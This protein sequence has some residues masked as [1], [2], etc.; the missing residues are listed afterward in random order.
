MNEFN[1]RCG[2]CWCQ[3]EGI[4]FLFPKNK[5]TVLQIGKESEIW[6]SGEHSGCYFELVQYTGS[7]LFSKPLESIACH[8]QLADGTT[9]CRWKVSKHYPTS[10]YSLRFHT[11][12]DLVVE[13]VAF[14]LSALVVEQE[15]PPKFLLN[16]LTS[17]IGEW[18]IGVAVPFKFIFASAAHSNSISANVSMSI[19]PIASSEASNACASFARTR[20][21]NRLRQNI[22]INSKMENF[23]HLYLSVDHLAFF[24]FPNGFRWQFQMAFSRGYLATLFTLGP[25]KPVYT[26]ESMFCSSFLSRMKGSFL[27]SKVEEDESFDE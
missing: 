18:P 23:I 27:A 9:S 11:S 4:S 25:F 14:V 22:T 15:G 1:G 17:G 5:M 19:M 10:V 8:L 26:I 6:V 7:W 16:S 21:T 2:F 3:S 20:I 12:N 24:M 13:S